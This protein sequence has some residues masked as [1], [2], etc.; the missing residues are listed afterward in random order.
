MAAGWDAGNAAESRAGGADPL[1]NWASNPSAGSS[2]PEPWTQV[3]S[4]QSLQNESG[5]GYT[6]GV[7]SYGPDGK[8]YTDDDI[9]TWPQEVE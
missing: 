8:E 6:V 7:W 9:T 2:T 1:P 3:S 5:Q 4:I